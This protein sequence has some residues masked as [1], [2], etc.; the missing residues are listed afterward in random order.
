M[1]TKPDKQAQAIFYPTPSTSGVTSRAISQD[2][3][4]APSPSA[5]IDMQYYLTEGLKDAEHRKYIDN[6]SFAGAVKSQT[7]AAEA[8]SGGKYV[9]FTSVSEEQLTTIDKLRNDHYKRLRFMYLEQQQTLIVK[10][11]A[12]ELHEVVHRKFEC[13]LNEKAARMGLP[14]DLGLIGG[15]R[16]KGNSSRKE[17]DSCYIPRSRVLAG[18]TRWPT[19]AV[20]SGVSQTIERLR[21]D[22]NW[23]IMNSSGAVNIV[24]VFSVKK[25]D[26]I[27]D[28]EQ[29]ETGSLIHRRSPRLNPPNPPSTP[30]KPKRVNIITIPQPD[31]DQRSLI[32]DFKKVFDRNPDRA[33]N[34]LESDFEFTP[35]DLSRLAAYIWF[36]GS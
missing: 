29:W 12:G 8:G 14:D 34:S 31:D 5:P 20:E 35:E 9:V 7:R 2:P 6:R 22:A 25:A 30:M 11:M 21:V 16:H 15:A 26:R 32:L 18:G 17:P 13:M 10:I 19:L 4:R 24:L 3:S 33:E 36:Y 27:I 23:W 28:I 1:A